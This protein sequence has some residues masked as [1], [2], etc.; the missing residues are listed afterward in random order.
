MYPRGQR[1]G[2]PEAL[3]QLVDALRALDHEAYLVPTPESRRQA[4]VSAYSP[5]DAPEADCYV[6]GPG[7]T[8][9]TYETRLHDLEAVHSG[10]PAVWWLS[11]DN[12]HAYGWQ[13]AWT[14]RA[15]WHTDVARALKA[16]WQ[17]RPERREFHRR[18]DFLRTDVLHLT[19]SFYAKDFLSADLGVRPLMVSDYIR[20]DGYNGGI[21]PLKRGRTIAFNP[22]RGHS[23][24]AAT[25]AALSEYTWTPIVDMTRSEVLDALGRSAV[26]VD[27]GHHPGRDRMPREA[28]LQGAVVVSSQFGA[29]GYPGDMDIPDRFLVRLSHSSSGHLEQTRQILERIFRHVPSAGAQQSSYRDW[30]RDAKDTFFTEVADAFQ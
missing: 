24:I 14:R 13:R 17:G 22:A 23:R 7:N 21:D 5:Y 12:S 4:R 10:R 25:A 9:I 29:G 16:G 19:Q 28:A 30:I 6:D 15:N 27:L 20:L 1:T 18:R 11:I 2:G 26:Y 8:L 3:H